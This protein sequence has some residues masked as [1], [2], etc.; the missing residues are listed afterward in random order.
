MRYV[1]ESAEASGLGFLGLLI[2]L[3]YFLFGLGLLFILF[4][5]RL[6]GAK[7]EKLLL[8]F[9]L[10]SVSLPALVLWRK[11]KGLTGECLNGYSLTVAHFWGQSE[12]EKHN[13]WYC[14]V[15][16]LTYLS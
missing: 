12:N 9:S 14:C 16:Y 13:V 6:N 3:A 11:D 4:D 2:G 8:P 15:V 10:P 1:L 7:L 5:R